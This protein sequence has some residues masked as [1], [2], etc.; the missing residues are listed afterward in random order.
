MLCD[1]CQQYW[2]GCSGFVLHSGQC[3]SHVC[4]RSRREPLE[5]VELVGTICLWNSHR[6]SAAGWG[7][8]KQLMKHYNSYSCSAWQSGK[9]VCKQ[10]ISSTDIWSLEKQNYN[11]VVLQLLIYRLNLGLINA[12]NSVTT[13][14]HQSLPVSLSSTVRMSRSVLDGGWSNDCRCLL[15]ATKHLRTSHTQIQTIIHCAY[16][17]KQNWGKQVKNMCTFTTIQP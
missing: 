14:P 10:R 8:W 12:E 7:Q 13:Y 15:L 2:Y 5:A 6:L 4:V 3:K 9:K 1:R 11:T 17:E 16:K